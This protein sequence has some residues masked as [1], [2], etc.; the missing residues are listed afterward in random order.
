MHSLNPSTED[1]RRWAA[2][3]EFHNPGQDGS[4][5]LNNPGTMQ[6]MVF[7]GAMRLPRKGDTLPPPDERLGVGKFG[8]GQ[9]EYI[10]PR[11]GEEGDHYGKAEKDRS[12]KGEQVEGK[13]KHALSTFF[14]RKKKE[15]A[16]DSESNEGGTVR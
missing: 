7:G 2:D 14:H 4:I 5:D 13:T 9:A 15:G 12:E 6:S 10:E 8:H 11:E 3:K 1:L 16:Y